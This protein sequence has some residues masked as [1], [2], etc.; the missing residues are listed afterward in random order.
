MALSYFINRKKT[1]CVVSFQGALSPNDVDILEEC[2]KE[3]TSTPVRYL[4]LNLAGLKGAD[5][6]AARPFTLFLQ[7]LRSGSKI[8][9]CDLQAEPGRILKASGVIRESEVQPDILTAL[10][11]ILN[12]EKG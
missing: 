2:L 7:A 8:Y 12:E 11:A 9:L 4:V 6:T 1:T 3:A 5:P 10:Q